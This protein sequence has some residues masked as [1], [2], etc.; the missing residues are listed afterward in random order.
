MKRRRGIIGANA[1]ANAVGVRQTPVR[2][3]GKVRSIAIVV[4]QWPTIEE[5]FDAITMH[6]NTG[7]VPLTV[8]QP[9]IFHWR[10]ISLAIL[11]VNIL[12]ASQ[13]VVPCINI[14]R[15]LVTIHSKDQSDGIHA[16]V[17]SKHHFKIV[18]LR[19]IAGQHDSRPLNFVDCEF[20]MYNFPDTSRC[21]AL[22]IDILN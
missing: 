18:L 1:N 10:D 11:P 3:E 9:Y 4:L 20:S 22:R 5:R 12:N 14:Q 16:R 2:M 13:E 8:G 15:R 17:S 21:V 19:D 7:R 6:A